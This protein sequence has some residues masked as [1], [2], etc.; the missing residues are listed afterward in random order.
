MVFRN[1]P[2]GTPCIRERVAEG[3][4]GLVQIPSEENLADIFTKPLPRVVHQKLVRALK[5][6][7]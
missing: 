1:F 3:E 2:V 4:I 7:T 6:D 5:L